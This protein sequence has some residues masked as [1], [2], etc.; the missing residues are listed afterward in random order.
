MRAGFWNGQE[1]KRKLGRLKQRGLPTKSD[2]S[3][4]LLLARPGMLSTAFDGLCES[5]FSD[6]LAGAESSPRVRISRM[7]TGVVLGMPVSLT[8]QRFTCAW[9]RRSGVRQ[10]ADAGRRH[11]EGSFPRRRMKGLFSRLFARF[12]CGQGP[13]TINGE[14][15]ERSLAG[16]GLGAASL[17]LNTKIP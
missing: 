9:Y 16:L 5:L 14:G 13:C 2:E 3:E 6:F 11:N 10:R 12:S 15:A 1:S 17:R 7:L 4:P 8:S